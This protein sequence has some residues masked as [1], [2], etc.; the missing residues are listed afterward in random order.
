MPEPGESAFTDSQDS[1]V[2]FPGPIS[3]VLEALLRVSG[4]SW[5]DGLARQH[6]VLILQ[7]IALAVLAT[8]CAYFV[9]HSGDLGVEGVWQVRRS[10]GGPAGSPREQ[11]VRPRWRSG[12]AYGGVLR[13]E[14]RQAR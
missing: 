9:L 5:L 8:L 1:S 10:G 13:M 3:G 6:A 2:D 4:F 11:A 12:A 14:L 7:R